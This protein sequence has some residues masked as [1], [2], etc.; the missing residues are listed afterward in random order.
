[1]PRFRSVLPHSVHVPL[2]PTAP[3]SGRGGRAVPG[4]LRA[5]P[6]GASGEPAVRAAAGLPG[7]GAA[8]V[9]AALRR[10]PH[11]PARAALPAR[12]RGAG[13]PRAHRHPAGGRAPLRAR[14]QRQVPAARGVLPRGSAPRSDQTFLPQGKASTLKPWAFAVVL[15]EDL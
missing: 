9:P 13:Q 4:A 1:M 2:R 5:V 11:L 15:R 14:G 7:P 6:A 10:P 8:R 12:R 3:V